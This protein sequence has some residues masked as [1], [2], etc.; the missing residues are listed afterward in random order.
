[1]NTVVCGL[2]RAG[3]KDIERAA[4][5][6]KPAKRA[7]IHTFISASPLHMKFKLQMEPDAV[8]QAVIDSVTL[9]RNLFD[10]V[11]WS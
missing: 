2:S 7:R 1:R 8:H 4:E 11:E 6:L 9:A 3:R 5:A 10:D